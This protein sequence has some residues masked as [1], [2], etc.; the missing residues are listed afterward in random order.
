MRNKTSTETNFKR[1]FTLVEIMV[2]VVI[3]GLLASIAIPGFTQSR[4]SSVASRMASDI[5]KFSDQFAVY[6]LREGDWPADGLPAGIPAGMETL[7]NGSWAE[8][9]AIGG[10]WD[11]DYDVFGITAGVSIQ[12]LTG[13]ESTLLAI[14]SLIDDGNLSTGSVVRMSSTH[15][16]Y[17]LVE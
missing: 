15:L 8:T 5:K 3:I 7:E 9:T 4:Q 10:N 13:D 14:D 11:W 6:N 17:I 1:G 12:G 2:V 16:C